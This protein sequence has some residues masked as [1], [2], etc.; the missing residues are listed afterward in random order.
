MFFV[1]ILMALVIWDEEVKDEDEVAGMWAV[2]REGHMVKMRAGGGEEEG[3][4]AVD[5]VAD[6]GVKG[7]E[8]VVIDGVEFGGYW[9]MVICK[10]LELDALN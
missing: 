3:G 10:C 5:V 7:R 8:I 1:S 4:E 9:V 6:G 2:R